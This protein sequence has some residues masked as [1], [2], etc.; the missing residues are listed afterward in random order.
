MKEFFIYLKNVFLTKGE[1]VAM[2]EDVSDIP[3]TKEQSYEVD[4]FNKKLQQNPN[5]I[6][7]KGYKKLVEKTVEFEYKFSPAIIHFP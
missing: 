3:L 6:L 5:Y 7:P 4:I 2:F 1:K